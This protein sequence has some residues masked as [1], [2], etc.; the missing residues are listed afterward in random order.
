VVQSVYQD[1]LEYFLNT[2]EADLG[3]M[4]D[5]VD[6]LLSTGFLARGGRTMGRDDFFPKRKPNHSY[7][8]KL[9]YDI[10][11]VEKI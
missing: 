10:L 1:D 6:H 3:E 5:E 9:V 8:G 2:Q 4:G 11:K 7:Y